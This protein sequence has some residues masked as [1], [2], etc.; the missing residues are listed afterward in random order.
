MDRS[1]SKN[2]FQRAILDRHKNI[3]L[4]QEKMH[5]IQLCMNYVL[6][7]CWKHVITNCAAFTESCNVSHT[8]SSVIVIVRVVIVAA[9]VLMLLLRL[10]ISFGLCVVAISICD[11]HDGVAHVVSFNRLCW[12]CDLVCSDACLVN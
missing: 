10:C 6:N 11:F 8:A 9:V 3:H 4:C 12:S 2:L 5:A 1:S 7:I